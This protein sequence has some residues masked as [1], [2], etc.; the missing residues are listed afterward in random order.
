M[1]A[2]ASNLPAV[3]ARALPCVVS[4]DFSGR[5]RAVWDEITNDNLPD[6]VSRIHKGQKLYPMTRGEASDRMSASLHGL[7]GLEAM[8]LETVILS[9]FCIAT[10]D[11]MFAKA[12]EDAARNLVQSLERL[13]E[14]VGCKE[15]FRWEI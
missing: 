14:H 12:G 5:I 6:L 8:I 1:S 11:L 3:S 4:V 7:D 13:L 2:P 9:W 15:V 10:G